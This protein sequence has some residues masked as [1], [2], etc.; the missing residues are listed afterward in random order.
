VDPNIVKLGQVWAL[1]EVG[2]GVVYQLSV[3]TGS[4]RQV[5]GESRLAGVEVGA[6]PL[7]DGGGSVD[8][9]GNALTEAEFA[10]GADAG[11]RQACFQESE[12]DA[13]RVEF[14]VVA[15]GVANVAT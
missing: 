1:G 5:L 4:R 13:Q 14:S 2:E 7:S 8:V 9:G 11:K 3:G 10:G 15:I 12:L 6:V